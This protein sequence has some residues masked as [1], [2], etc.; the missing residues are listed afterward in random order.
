MDVQYTS[1]HNTATTKY[2]GPW[3]VVSWTGQRNENCNMAMIGRGVCHFANDSTYEG[4]MQNDIM[5]DPC[6]ILVDTDSKSRYTGGFV[7]DRRE[8]SAVFEHPYGRYEG[9]YLNNRRHGMGKEVDLNGNT[10]T[11]IFVDGDAVEGRM[12]YSDGSVYVGAM[13][14]G[15]REGKGKLLTDDG[16]VLEGDWKDDELVIR[17]NK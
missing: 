16:D 12:E 1:K 15:S 14:D 17:R 9:E 5:H 3:A 4:I 8:G 6:A 10:F 2:T 11:G 13:R 7:D